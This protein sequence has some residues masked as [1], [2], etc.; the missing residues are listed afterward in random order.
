MNCPRCNSPAFYE[1]ISIHEFSLICDFC[2]YYSAKHIE[3]FHNNHPIFACSL[4][5]PKGVVITNKENYQY[6]STSQREALLHTHPD[7][8]GYTFY[9]TTECKWKVHNKEYADELN[10]MYL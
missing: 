4:L 5:E 3:H 10:S 2:G 8:E 9:D 7:N 1:Q 6:F